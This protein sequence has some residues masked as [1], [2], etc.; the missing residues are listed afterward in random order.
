MTPSKKKDAQPQPQPAP[1][2]VAGQTAPATP[3]KAEATLNKLK[4]AWTKRG[5][6]LTKMIVRTEGKRTLVEVGESWP[7]IEIGHG[8][9]I[10][11]PQ[12]R[13]YAN[14][15]NAAVD[16]DK[17]FARQTERDSKKAAAS[18]QPA[19]KKPAPKQA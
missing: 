9:G 18:A 10:T 17:L 6:V 3:T 1:P 13:S 15:F 12:I 8:G 7:L 11:L 16:G 4:E 5:V 14:A 19:A 2:P